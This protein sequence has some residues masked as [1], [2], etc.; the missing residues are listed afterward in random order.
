VAYDQT[1]DKL[2]EQLEERR[3]D[4]RPCNC[5]LD[6][7]AQDLYASFSLPTFPRSLVADTLSSYE[8]GVSLIFEDLVEEVVFLDAR[9]RELPKKKIPDRIF[10]LKVTKNIEEVITEIAASEQGWECTP[11]GSAANPPIFPFLLLEAKS[12][13]S[14]NGFHDIQTQT[15]FPIR[16]ILNLQRELQS[17]MQN[18]AGGPQPLVWFLGNRGSE[19][20]VYGCYTNTTTKGGPQY[21]SSTFF[22]ILFLFIY[23]FFIFLQLL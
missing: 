2:R 22:S 17:K 1:S 8:T 6:S 18:A 14:R 7:R 3:R 23:L 20:K 21:V 13:S 10:G 12:D 5:P 15:A 9:L 16:R 19:W 4:R 11:F